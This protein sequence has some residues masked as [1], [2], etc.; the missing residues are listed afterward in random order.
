MLIY[1]SATQPIIE[2]CKNIQLSAYDGNYF[3][4]QQQFQLTKLSSWNTEYSN[5]HD[6]TQNNN[7]KLNWSYLPYNTRLI[8]FIPNIATIDGVDCINDNRQFVVPYTYGNRTKLYNQSYVI[9]IDIQ[10]DDVVYKLLDQLY[11]TIQ[12]QDVV[13]I[14]TR[15]IKLSPQQYMTLTNTKSISI[16]SV[17]AIEFDTKS[18]ELITDAIQHVDNNDK[19]MIPLDIESSIDI[20]F[21]PLSQI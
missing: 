6:F 18:H 20:L 21:A 11:D 10:Y 12:L 3:N 16:Q 2:S 19:I 17:I 9:F 5:V 1:V 13:L 8:D 15:E 4:L 7:N 14:R